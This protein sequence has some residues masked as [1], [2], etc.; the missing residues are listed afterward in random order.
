ME[1]G[2]VKEH[3]QQQLAQAVTE[4]KKTHVLPSA[5]GTTGKVSRIV[6][7]KFEG[8]RTW[9]IKCV[10]SQSQAKRPVSGG[11]GKSKSKAYYLRRGT[12]QMKISAQERMNLY[13]SVLWF[14]LD[15]QR[16][17]N[18]CHHC[19]DN[20]HLYSFYWLMPSSSRNTF[21]FRPKIMFCSFLGIIYKAQSS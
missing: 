13:S 18:A 11:K 7:F 14:S 4:T 15:T 20:D 10:K 21:T 17:R 19:E 12:Y 8:L 3:L 5:S 16:T 1:T 2:I 6:Q 9:E